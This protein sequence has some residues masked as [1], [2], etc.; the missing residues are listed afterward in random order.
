M[1]NVSSTDGCLQRPRRRAALAVGRFF[2][3]VRTLR[4]AAGTRR[5]GPAEPARRLGF[6]PRLDRR[7]VSLDFRPSPSALAMSPGISEGV[8]ATGMPAS[9]SRAI[10]SCAVPDPPDTMA[11]ACPMRFP[12]GAVWP[13]TKATTGFVI[14][15]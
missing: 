13:A 4:F 6:D 14:E 11:P 10:F 8:L 7:S 9:W 12:G 15:R 5:L 2:E 1:N 3:V